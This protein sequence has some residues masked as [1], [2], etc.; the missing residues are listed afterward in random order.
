[1]YCS[2]RL[3]QAAGGRE[4]VVN[5]ISSLAESLKMIDVFLPHNRSLLKC[6]PLEIAG[7][8]LRDIMGQYCAD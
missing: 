1:V 3:I 4:D 6:P 7:P 8:Y 2:D 5:V